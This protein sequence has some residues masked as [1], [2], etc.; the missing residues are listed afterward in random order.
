V[1]G[2][3]RLDI[4]LRDLATSAR[5]ADRLE[6]HVAL[7]GQASGHGRRAGAIGWLGDWLGW[8]RDCG[9]SVTRAVRRRWA[10]WLTRWLRLRA[11]LR[12]NLAHGDGIAL[13]LEDAGQHAV[14]G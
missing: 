13:V 9:G 10:R 4:I 14:A 2:E 6:I 8:R 11:D 7:G 3:I 12:Q 1:T 5:P